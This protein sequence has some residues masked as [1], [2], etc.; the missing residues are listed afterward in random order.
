MKRV[1]RIDYHSEK[2]LSYQKTRHEL[3]EQDM[4]FNLSL[5]MNFLK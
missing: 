1:S 5:S 2:E 3:R 4:E